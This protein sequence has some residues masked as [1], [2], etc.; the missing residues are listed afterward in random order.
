MS[1]RVAI[2]DFVFSYRPRFSLSAL[3]KE[4]HLLRKTIEPNAAMHQARD[5]AAMKKAVLDVKDFIHRLPNP[6]LAPEIQEDFNVAHE[7]VMV[8]K[9]PVSKPKKPTLNTE[10]LE[11]LEY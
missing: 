2:E 10:D 8:E 6:S 5:K 3:L 11:Y 4:G 1:L 7:L 9:Q